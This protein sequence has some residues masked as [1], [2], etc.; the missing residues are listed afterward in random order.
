MNI[1]ETKKNIIQAG[2]RAVDE[3]IKVA[4]EEIVDTG[5]DISAA[6]YSSIP[7]S[8]VSIVAE[9]NNK[10]ELIDRFNSLQRGP[11]PTPTAAA[12]PEIVPKADRETLSISD[13]TNL[14]RESKNPIVR[15]L[16]RILDDAVGTRIKGQGRAINMS[17]LGQELGFQESRQLEEAL[18]SL[19]G[20]RSRTTGQL[21][22]DAIR[23]V[24]MRIRGRAGF[25]NER[26]YQVSNI[27]RFADA[28]ENIDVNPVRVADDAPLDRIN[29]LDLPESYFDDAGELLDEDTFRAKFIKPLSDIV[30]DI[31]KP[32]A[33][34][35]SVI[36]KLEK[37]M[38]QLEDSDALD[39]DGFES[40]RES[41]DEYVVMD[42]GD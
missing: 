10:R 6:T 11:E 3:L 12:V 20:N 2:Y 31:D 8:K 5:D 36:R 26:G 21:T 7:I 37:K 35:K 39:E 32:K 38:E 42:R 14:L 13:R 34:W 40:I 19:M 28:L 4:K 9:G 33:G 30:K 22:D 27:D 41:I 15:E 16:M 29:R 18:V 25:S 23:Q 24:P 1:K 17:D